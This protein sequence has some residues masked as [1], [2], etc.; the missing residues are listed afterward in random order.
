MRDQRGVVA[1]IV[2]ICL[3]A[4]IGFTAVV[5]DLGHWYQVQRH[6]QTQADA[7]ALA[8]ADQLL[9]NPATCTQSSL[10]TAADQYAAPNTTTTGSDP[11][12]SS[13]VQP[14]GQEG[15]VTATTSVACPGSGSYVDVKMDNSSPSSF[16]AGGFTPTISAHARVSVLQVGSA[17]GSQVLPYAITK[18]EAANCCNKLVGL[19]I[20]Y[21]ST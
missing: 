10:Q 14:N 16:F 2:A 6:L 15:K 9:Q 19:P 13:G 8:G 4:F 7:G 12:P 18:T 5:V 3:V 20:N 17:G 11:V 21:S 1:V